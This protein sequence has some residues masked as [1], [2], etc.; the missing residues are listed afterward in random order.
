MLMKR[1]VYSVYGNYYENQRYLAARLSRE[2]GD[3]YV[4]V[5]GLGLN[6]PTARVGVIEVKPMAS[7]LMT[8][9]AATMAVDL[10]KHGK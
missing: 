10:E 5:F 7:G 9:S 8:V 1:V 6:D 4:S 2:E 3:I